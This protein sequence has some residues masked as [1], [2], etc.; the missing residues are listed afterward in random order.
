MYIAQF[1]NFNQTRCNMRVNFEI[2]ISNNNKN[3]SKTSN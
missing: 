3:T 2:Y 1:Y